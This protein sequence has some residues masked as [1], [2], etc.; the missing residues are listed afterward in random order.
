MTSLLSIKSFCEPAWAVVRFE[1]VLQFLSEWQSTAGATRDI[2]IAHIHSYVVV[3]S[4]HKGVL[5]TAARVVVPYD[6]AC[7][8][9]FV[10]STRV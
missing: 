9:S 4:A 2:R 8:I 10:L 5:V 3:D 7:S 1:F 6:R